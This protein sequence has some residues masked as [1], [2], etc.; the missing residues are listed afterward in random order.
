[1]WQA[2]MMLMT[3]PGEMFYLDGEG[4]RKGQERER[5][6]FLCKYQAVAKK[7]KEMGRMLCKYH[8]THKYH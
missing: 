6:R 5:D 1:M 3:G 7:K 2:Q 4:V 8:I